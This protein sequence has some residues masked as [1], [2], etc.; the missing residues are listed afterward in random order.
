MDTN[1]PAVVLSVILLCVTLFGTTLL[2]FKA[3]STDGVEGV[4]VGVASMIFAG[5]G[6]T[7]TLRSL[8]TAVVTLDTVYRCLVL[9]PVLMAVA[10]GVVCANYGKSHPR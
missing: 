7:L 4:M 10:M 9:F 8:S 6:T 3:T 2:S 5:L 1:T